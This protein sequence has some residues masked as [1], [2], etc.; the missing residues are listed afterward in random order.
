MTDLEL[1]LIGNGTIAAL[2]NPVGEIVWGCVPRLDGDP[3][4]CSLLRERGGSS[5]FGYFTID[6]IDFEYGPNNSWWHTQDDTVDKCSKD[7]LSVVGRLVLQ[8]P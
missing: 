1:A 8:K 2:V 3:V 6:L 5:D 4:F 7:S